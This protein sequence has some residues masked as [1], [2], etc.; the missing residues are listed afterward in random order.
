MK[1]IKTLN[2][3]YLVYIDGIYFF[4]DP[5]GNFLTLS[6]EGEYEFLLEKAGDPVDAPEPKKAPH[7][8]VA[9]FVERVKTLKETGELEGITFRQAAGIVRFATGNDVCVNPYDEG[10][11]KKSA[12]G[13]RSNGSC[14]YPTIHALDD[15]GF[16]Y[17]TIKGRS[18]YVYPAEENWGIDCSEWWLGSSRFREKILNSAERSLRKKE[19]ADDSL[20]EPIEDECP[21]EE[22]MAGEQFTLY[23][24]SP[25]NHGCSGDEVV[26]K[27]TSATEGV[28]IDG[29]SCYSCGNGE[30]P[31]EIGSHV[32]LPEG[33][34][35]CWRHASETNPDS[36]ASR[37]VSGNGW[38]NVSPN[39]L[40]VIEP[41]ESDLPVFS[42]GEKPKF[43]GYSIDR[44]GPWPGECA[45]SEEMYELAEQEAPESWDGDEIEFFSSPENFGKE[46]TVHLL[47]YWP[48]MHTAFL[49]T[50]V[51]LCPTESV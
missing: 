21:L 41:E 32:A 19:F 38:S 20:P 46:D 18:I 44:W 9:L 36:L 37:D 29:S 6:D 7:E 22:E 48:P 15:G 35:C 45:A 12:L 28:V 30:S 8:E 4:I 25:N 33:V 31:I 17:R 40:V 50:D 14:D 10:D 24:I 47:V 39:E 1:G 34:C 16:E 5:A 51:P 26:I 13:F 42:I 11:I 3:N 49:D 27:A 43:F 2:G 23:H